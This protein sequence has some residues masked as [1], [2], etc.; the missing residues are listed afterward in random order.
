MMTQLPYVES[1]TQGFADTEHAC[2][3]VHAPEKQTLS[4]VQSAAPGGHMFGTGV[5]A[6]R[7]GAARHLNEETPVDLVQE[8]FNMLEL[9]TRQSRCATP[10]SISSKATKVLLRQ[11]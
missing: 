10:L 2:Q 4:E 1:T 5:A 3:Q 7:R 6:V 11:F 9:Q 8:R